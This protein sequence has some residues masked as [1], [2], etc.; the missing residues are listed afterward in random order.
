[1]RL[2]SN[3]KGLSHDSSVKKLH[4]LFY[5]VTL[6]STI[7]FHGKFR[8]TFN[9]ENYSVYH[10]QFHDFCWPHCYGQIFHA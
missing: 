6:R 4:C 9:L 5:I 1:M 8:E 10:T 2:R 7:F 3:L